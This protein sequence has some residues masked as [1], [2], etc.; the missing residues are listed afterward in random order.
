MLKFKLHTTDALVPTKAGP[1]ESGYDLTAISFVKKRG[2]HTFMYDTGVSVEVPS[3]Y[4]TEIVPRS[5]ISKTG[6]VLSNSIGVID[7]TY[8]GTLKIVLTDVDSE[9]RNNGISRPMTCPFTLAQLIVRKRHDLQ[10]EVVSEL[11]ET[12]RGDGGFGSTGAAGGNTK[13]S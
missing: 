1:E 9:S 4:Y 10:V 8:R 6:F 5:S 2:K 13:R 11:S 3:G 12:V 7:A